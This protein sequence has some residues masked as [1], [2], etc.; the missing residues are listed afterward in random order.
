MIKSRLLCWFSSSASEGSELSSGS[1]TQSTNLAQRPGRW[2][3]LITQWPFLHGRAPDT[4]VIAPLLPR[5]SVIVPEKL[6][7]TIACST[8]DSNDRCTE[9][10]ATT[11]RPLLLHDQQSG[12]GSD[13]YVGADGQKRDVA[14][15]DHRCLIRLARERHQSRSRHRTDFRRIV[16]YFCQNQFRIGSE[17]KLFVERQR[18]IGYQNITSARVGRETVFDWGANSS[19]SPSFFF[20]RLK[21]GGKRRVPRPVCRPETALAVSIRRRRVFQLE[22]LHAASSA[23]SRVA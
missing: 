19:R 4:A 16:L 21:T 13:A 14:S 9:T 11:A 7:S 23:K 17:A 20:R 22:Q 18:V 6:Y 12:G 2:I 3:W 15:E 1:W 8:K 5:R 10:V